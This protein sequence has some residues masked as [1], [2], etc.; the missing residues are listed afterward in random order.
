MRI[1]GEDL[2][3]MGLGRDRKRNLNCLAG[4]WTTVE[5][6]TPT[7][8]YTFSIKWIFYVYKYFKPFGGVVQ[9]H[10]LE[11]IYIGLQS[12]FVIAI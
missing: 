11:I 7:G 3:G 5:D 2:K 4:T 8:R 9:I 1:T 10:M 6:D 12:Y